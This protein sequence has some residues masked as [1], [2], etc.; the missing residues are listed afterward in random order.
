[1]KTF[2]G[3]VGFG[4]RHV[5]ALLLAMAASGSA[6]SSALAA[7]AFP[8]NVMLV[9]NSFSSIQNSTNTAIL[10]VVNR[11]TSPFVSGLATDTAPGTCGPGIWSRANGGAE[12]TSG[13]LEVNVHYAGIELGG[14]IACFGFNKSNVDI[15]IGVIGGATRGDGAVT[16]LPGTVTFDQRYAGIYGTFNSGSLNGDLQLRGDSISFDSHGIP[17][18]NDGT[19]VTATRAGLSGSLNYTLK[20]TDDMS[21]VPAVGF[22]VSRTTA[23]TLTFQDL[24]FASVGNIDSDIGFIGATLAKTVALP[25]GQSAV[26]PF[27]T[28]TYYGDFSP[29]VSGSYTSGGF[30]VP[31][32]LNAAGSFGEVSAGLNYVKVLSGSVGPAKQLTA[33]IRG[34]YKFNTALQGASLTGQVRL[35]Y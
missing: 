33:G 3:G 25:D 35:Q 30:A 7:A 19:A 16:G 1:M 27:V 5:A 9:I 24:S 4:H 10:G 15:S 21:L 18:V 14:D 13:A 28:A 2:R 6:A 20:L 32:S 22:D 34:D 17:G 23:S 31:F 11:P 26:V 12:K 29:S 8:P